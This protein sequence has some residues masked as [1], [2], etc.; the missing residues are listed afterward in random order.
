[1]WQKNAIAKLSVNER[2][3]ISDKNSNVIQ[4]GQGDVLQRVDYISTNYGMRQ[5][6]MCKVNTENGLFWF[7]YYNKCI[8]AF[9]E[10]SVIDYTDVKN[11]KSIMYNYK[12]DKN[13]SL[14]YDQKHKELLFGTI[15]SPIDNNDAALV[16]NIKYN[17][18]VGLYYLKFSNI[19]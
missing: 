2:S 14:A 17:I 5:Y 16:I 9:A 1:M 8:A 4:L 15:P 10:N 12:D 19:L 18:P 3:L 6:D 11:I 7:D 13:P